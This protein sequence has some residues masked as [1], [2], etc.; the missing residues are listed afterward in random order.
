MVDSVVRSG[1]LFGPG[2]PA[3]LLACC[4]SRYGT[5]RAPRWWRVLIG[6]TVAFAAYLRSQDHRRTVAVSETPCSER[7]AIAA[8]LH[9]FVA[10]ASWCR[11]RW[12][13]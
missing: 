10:H 12:L 5:V 4:S 13:A 7:L 6:L 3:I 1:A 9:H 8:D 11:P 2:A